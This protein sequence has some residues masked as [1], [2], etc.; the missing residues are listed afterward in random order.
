MA[1][2]VLLTPASASADSGDF[3]VAPDAKTY[4]YAR[5]VTGVT[6]LPQPEWEIQ[7]MKK[8]GSDYYVVDKLNAAKNSCILSGAGTFKVRRPGLCVIVGCDQET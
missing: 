7:I 4:L 3:T 5:P 2:T 1:I 6:E 8:T